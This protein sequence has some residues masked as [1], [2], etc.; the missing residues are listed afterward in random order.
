M[1]L[2]VRTRFPKSSYQYDYLPFSQREKGIENMLTIYGINYFL[3]IQ[4]N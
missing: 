4:M 3:Y 1:P 2:T